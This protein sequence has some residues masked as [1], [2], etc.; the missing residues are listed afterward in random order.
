MI[1]RHAVRDA[2][3]AVLADDGEALEAEVLHDVD[4]VLR[5]RALRVVRVVGQ[6]LRL[7]AVAVT[8]Q[9]R[10]DDREALGERGRDVAPRVQRQR[11]AVQQ[12]Q[13]R[14]AAGFRRR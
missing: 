3:A 4:L 13:R 12:Q 10:G 8:A 2:A 9:D 1:E 5:H 11:R 7:A 6:A 14:P